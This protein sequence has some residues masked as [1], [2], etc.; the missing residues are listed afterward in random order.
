MLNLNVYLNGQNLSLV[1]N[2]MHVTIGNEL[3]VE[4]AVTICDDLFWQVVTNFST[5]SNVTIKRKSSNFR[6]PTP[7][8]VSLSLRLPFQP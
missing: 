5:H 1:S 6:V 8:L 2:S 4:V 7:F 3:F